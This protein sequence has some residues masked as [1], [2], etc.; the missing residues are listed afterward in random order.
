VV[1]GIDRVSD[2]IVYADA[3]AVDYFGPDLPGSTLATPTDPIG[4]VANPAA[5]LAYVANV[6]DQA[7]TFFDATGV[8]YA[9]GS[10]AASTFTVDSGGHVAVDP[11]ANRL[12]VGASQAFP[13]SATILDA[14]TGAYV[15]GSLAQSVFPWLTE[16]GMAVNPNNGVVFA[17]AGIV[18]L[19]G[20]HVVYYDGLTGTPLVWAPAVSTQP[21]GPSPIAI[22]AMQP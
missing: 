13:R 19:V 5:G 15:N 10:F 1:Y 7:V 9:F 3:T 11:V 17:Y 8:G 21:A 16:R 4:V 14:T 20:E 12:Y 2:S 6:A 18:P 22:D